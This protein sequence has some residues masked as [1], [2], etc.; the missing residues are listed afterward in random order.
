MERF[1]CD[2]GGEMKEYVGCRLERNW[3][4]GW[5]KVTQPVLLQSFTDE[6]DL[7]EGNYPNTPA[8]PG[9]VL[10]VSETQQ[11]LSDE[12]QRE[13]R[14]GTGKLL[15]LAKKSRPEILNSVRELSRF[16]ANATA[17][18]LTAM[19]RVMKYCVGT[20]K[21]GLL[22]QP[23]EKWN[24]DPEF[25]FKI[26]GRAD[27]DYA[28]DPETRRSVSGYSTFLC[29]AP[30][31][32]KSRM[33]GHA[34]L[35]TT[36]AEQV[37][38]VQCAQDMLFIMRV[39][40]SMGLKVQKP[41]IMEVDNKGAVDLTNNWSVG[42]RTRHVDVRMH[43]LRELKEQG[44]LLVVWVSNKLMSSDLFTKNLAGPDF[45]QHT[46]VYCGHDE[47]MKDESVEDSQGEGVTGSANSD[48]V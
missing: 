44:L 12:A 32:M 8:T 1:D 21:R 39:L 13:Y 29:G 17:G 37:S 40:E 36:E 14:K 23:N 4:E 2:D 48:G 30:V 15:H 46:A 6:F 35:S 28:K 31:T 43:F 25:E 26:F 20:P 18:C 42:G 16:M 5:I 22:L 9:S 11:K 45:Q 38:A 41:M 27:S 47:Y 24:G 10:T 33:Q 3:D 19:Y 7:P 34:T